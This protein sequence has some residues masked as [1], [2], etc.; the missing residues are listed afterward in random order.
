MKESHHCLLFTLAP[1]SGDDVCILVPKDKVGFHVDSHRRPFI[2]GVGAASAALR[3]PA[4]GAATATL[5]V[6]LRAVTTALVP[7]TR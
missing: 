1:F 7:H 2:P 4:T 3:L 5:S 6:R